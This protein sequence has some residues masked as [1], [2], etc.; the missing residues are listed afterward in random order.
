MRTRTGALA[1]LLCGVLLISGCGGGGGDGASSAD[2]TPTASAFSSGPIT[3]FGSVIVNGVRFDDSSARITDDDGN[4]RGRDDLR[5]GMRV[6]IESSSVST[7]ANGSRAAARSIRLASELVGPVDS[8][9]ADGSSIV[10]LG[11]TVTITASTLLDNR[12]VGGIGGLVAGTSVVEVHGQIDA[13]TGVFTATRIEPKTGAALFKLR[14][15]VANLDPAAHTFTIGSAKISYDA[16][17]A[18]VPA[19]LSNGQLV[20]VKVQTTQVAGAWIATTIENAARRLDDHDEAEIEGTITAST[21]DSD[22]R[23]SVD[24]IPVDAT[25]ATFQNG[26]TGLVVGARVEIHGRASGGVIIATRVNLEDASGRDE[27]GEFE[28]HGAISAFDSVAKTFVV[29]GVTVSFAGVGVEFRNGVVGQLANGALV[30]VK[31]ARAADGS[32]LVATRIEFEH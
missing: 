9:A 10:V 3:G 6:E 20:R 11:Q 29:R 2:S 1:H 5:L 23:F 13:S 26:T 25:N 22:H 19:T 31:G 16:I 27:R 17:A 30:E 8:V 14:G 4:N 18:L 28:L 7:D 15:V 21:F 24:G 32:T 12:L